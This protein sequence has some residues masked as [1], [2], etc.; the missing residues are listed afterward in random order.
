MAV[1]AVAFIGCELE[2][3]S[4]GRLGG[5]GT[6]VV[7]RIGRSPVRINSCCHARDQHV[8]HNSSNGNLGEVVGEE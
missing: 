6:L 5:L 4:A 8:N 1:E 3:V 2:E 7:R